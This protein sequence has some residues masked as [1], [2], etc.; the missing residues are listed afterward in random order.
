MRALKEVERQ[1]AEY[2]P[3]TIEPLRKAAD[4]ADDQDEL[5]EFLTRIVLNMEAS[6]QRWH[7]P[8]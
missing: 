1:D 7:W 8:S 4:A 6:A 3:E 5:L 2:L